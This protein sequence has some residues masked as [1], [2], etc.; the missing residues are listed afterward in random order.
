M[1]PPNCDRFVKIMLVIY[2]E[3][4][5][6]FDVIRQYPCFRYVSYFIFLGQHITAKS[7]YIRVGANTIV[8]MNSF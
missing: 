8:G 4:I 2:E 5:K 7:P 1:S 3:T 6:L